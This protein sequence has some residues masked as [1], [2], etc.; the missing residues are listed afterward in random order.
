VRRP[1]AAAA[2]TASRP[3]GAAQRPSGLAS[4]CWP[5]RPSD[6]AVAQRSDWP[7]CGDGGWVRWRELIGVRS[8]GRSGVRNDS[9][10]RGGLGEEREKG[11]GR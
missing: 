4:S 8:C 6:G 7:T 9:K 10:G 11:P 3:E 5:A 2:I 1:A